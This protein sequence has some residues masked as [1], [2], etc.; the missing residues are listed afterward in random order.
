MVIVAGLT[1]SP[2]VVE[3][4][5][6]LAVALVSPAKLAVITLEPV[7]TAVTGTV[8][9]VAPTAMMTEAGTVALAVLEEL[10]VKVRPPAGA[11][12]ERFSERFCE[13]GATMERFAGEKLIVAVT[14][15]D[16]EPVV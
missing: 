8:A 15:T 6:T 13:P 16:C 1:I 3:V 11:G 4:I 9:V 14:L 7:A 5:V 10:K 2:E 12:A